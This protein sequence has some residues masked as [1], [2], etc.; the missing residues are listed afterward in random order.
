MFPFKDPMEI[1][2]ERADVCYTVKINGKVGIDLCITDT[3][4]KAV[5]F[6]KQ[7]ILL[8]RPKFILKVSSEETI[9]KLGH[10][11]NGTAYCTIEKNMTAEGDITLKNVP[12]CIEKVIQIISKK[13]TNI[14]LLTKHYDSEE[15]FIDIISLEGRK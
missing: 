4:G 11:M 3:R 7:K 1:W 14:Y 5:A 8:L 2:D 10:H 9:L 6:I 15:R 13:N 12:K